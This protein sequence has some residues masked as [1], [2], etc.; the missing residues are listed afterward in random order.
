MQNALSMLVEWVNTVRGGIRLSTDANATARRLL[1]II[2]VDD[3]SLDAN[4]APITKGLID[5]SLLGPIGACGSVGAGV[6]FVLGPY[7]SGLTEL[8]AKAAD[9]QGKLLMAAGAS[10][11]SVFVN[12]SL[13][14]GML[15]PAATYMHAGIELLYALNVRSIALLFEDASATKDWCKGAA[16]KAAQ[17][18]MTVVDS[19]QISQKLNRTEIANALARFQAAGTE[20]SFWSVVIGANPIGTTLVR[21]AGPDVVVGCTYFEACA[22]FLTQ[23]SVALFTVKA[24]LLT[25]CVTDARFLTE[26]AAKAAYVLGVSPWSEYDTQPDQLMGSGWSPA[27]FAQKYEA[28]FNQIPPYQAVAA[29]AG[30]CSAPPLGVAV[31]AV[32]PPRYVPQGV[33]CR[34]IAAH[35]S[36]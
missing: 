31:I 33:Q 15:P 3:G 1:Q 28:R 19:V 14:F 27:D 12:R 5:G 32:I 21:H 10:T 36:N 18:N 30:D 23:A 24:T 29:F 6:D 13:A 26:L 16:A 34:R 4:I 11:T 20:L 9:A 8:A 7:S 17:L 25:T 2:T 22:E 35:S